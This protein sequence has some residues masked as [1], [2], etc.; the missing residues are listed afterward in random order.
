MKSVLW[1]QTERR[2]SKH[3]RRQAEAGHVVW[4]QFGPRCYW[5][6]SFKPLP[7]RHGQSESSPNNP[8]RVRNVGDYP[9]FFQRHGLHGRLPLDC[10]VLASLIS[11]RGPSVLPH[12]HLDRRLPRSSDSWQVPRW[13]CRVM[14]WSTVRS[15][16]LINSRKRWTPAAARGSSTVENLAQA[17]LD[18]AASTKRASAMSTSSKI[19]TQVWFLDTKD[20]IIIIIIIIRPH[21]IHCIRCGLLLSTE[22]SVRGRSVCLCVCVCLLVTLANPVKTVERFGD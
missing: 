15:S 16:W 2:H 6:R 22:Y 14:T 7:C 19:S 3:I 20:F 4:K 9:R 21:L 17:S 18:C 5:C 1:I 8:H 13:C 10:S 12:C 11:S